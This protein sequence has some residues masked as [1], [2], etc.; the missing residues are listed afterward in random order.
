[1]MSSAAVPSQEKKKEEVER[2]SERW[3]ASVLVNHE[4]NQKTKDSWLLIIKS[5]YRFKSKTH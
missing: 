2:Q 4:S 5:R 3:R 1:M